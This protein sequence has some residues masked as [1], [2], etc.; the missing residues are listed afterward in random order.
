MEKNKVQE[1]LNFDLDKVIARIKN[2]RKQTQEIENIVT[3]DSEKRGPFTD[4]IFK[5]MSQVGKITKKL[6]DF[7]ENAKE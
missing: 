7:L 3:S 2:I 6:Q 1:K 5:K 4:Y